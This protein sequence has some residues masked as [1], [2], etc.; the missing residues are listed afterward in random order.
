MRTRRTFLTQCAAFVPASMM[1][2]WNGGL[3][4]DEPKQSGLNLAVQTWTFKNFDI[5]T[6]IRKTKE[7]GVDAV[8]IAGGILIGTTQ[9]R[10][11]ATNKE[12]RKRIKDVLAETGVKAISLGGSQGGTEDFDFAADFGLLRL[13]GEPPFDKLVEVS[14]RAEKYKV[15]FTLHNH[16]KPSKYWNYKETLKRLDGTTSYLGFCPDTG[17]FT[18]SGIDP[19]QAIKDLEGHIFAVHLKDLNDTLQ[20]EEQKNSLHDVPWGT[21]KGQVEAIL[22]ELLRQ[23]VNGTVIIEYEYDWNN[24]LAAVAQCAKFF[25]KIVSRQN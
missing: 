15:Q 25:H 18:R 13:Q 19:L 20:S 11:S 23:K 8:E 24:N 4:A 14:E 7:A 17:H 6:A 2:R 21:G 10:A 22:N 16:P 3:F 1:L 9:K 5:E 12:E